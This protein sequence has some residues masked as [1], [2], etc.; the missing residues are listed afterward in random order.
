M[1]WSKAKNI[2]IISFIFTNIFLAYT[3]FSVSQSQRKIEVQDE[4]I[5]DVVELLSKK[6]IEIDTDIPGEIPS[7]PIVSVEYEVYDTQRILERFLGYY[8]EESWDGLKTYRNGEKTVRF[9]SN[10]KKIIYKD[11]GLSKKE[12]KD[13]LSQEKAIKK[14]EDFIRTHGF[15]LKDTELSLVVKEGGIYKLYYN[16]VIDD[17]AVEQTNMIVELSSQGV[18]SFER[19][20]I[21]RIDKEKQ[22]LKPT[23]AYKALL[24]LLAREQY[25]GKTIKDIEICYYFNIDDYGDDDLRD[26]RGGVAVPTWKI[27]FQDGEKVFLEEN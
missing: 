22:I 18:I 15:D 5:E 17:V 21:Y 1:D 19:Y 20:W 6:S 13:E 4:F 24:R 3:L 25:Y 26:S 10:N 23:S 11:E 12:L 7:M 27:M 9:E 8:K 2:L 16:K 14:G